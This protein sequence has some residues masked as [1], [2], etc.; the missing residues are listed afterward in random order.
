MDEKNKYTTIGIISVSVICLIFL[1]ILAVCIWLND[2]Y[3]FSWLIWL[4]LSLIIP[5]A[6]GFIII[7]IIT[8]ISSRNESD[9]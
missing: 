1:S 5:V 2:K 6:I 9:I 4:N 8:L 3:D 7:C